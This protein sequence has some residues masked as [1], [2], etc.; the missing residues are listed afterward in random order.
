MPDDAIELC[1]E[2]YCYSSLGFKHK[3]EDDWRDVY[4]RTESRCKNTMKQSVAAGLGLLRVNKRLHSETAPVFW[5]ENEFRFSNITGWVALDFFLHKIGLDKVKM[6]RKLTVCHPDCCFVPTSL[7]QAMDFRDGSPFFYMGETKEP[8][9]VYETRWFDEGASRDPVLILQKAGKLKQ[10]RLVSPVNTVSPAQ[11][12]IKFVSNPF[13]VT[14][15]DRLEVT[16]VSL[17]VPKPIKM[18]LFTRFAPELKDR[19]AAKRMARRRFQQ[20][21]EMWKYE[22]VVVDEFGRY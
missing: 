1:P 8:G 15:F 4:Q 2:P 22:D 14:C 19:R 21:G 17:R 5:G 16:V 20:T 3:R 6:L 7:K 11:E 12:D 9:F 18:D 13:D 10:L